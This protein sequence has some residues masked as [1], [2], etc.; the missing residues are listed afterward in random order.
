MWKCFFFV[1]CAHPCQALPLGVNRPKLCK[2]KDGVHFFTLEFEWHNRYNK[3]LLC[4]SENND[5]AWCN[6]VFPFSLKKEQ[7]LILFLFKKTKK[8][9]FLKKPQKTGGLFFFFEKKTGFSQPCHWSYMTQHP[10]LFTLINYCIFICSN[11]H[12]W[13]V[14]LVQWLLVVLLLDGYVIWNNKPL[15]HYCCYSEN[16]NWAAQNLRLGHGFDITGL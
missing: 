14:C 15:C 13:L 6:K 7:N 2:N 8:T 9:C 5:I 11:V 3:L 10:C 1:C 12:Y 16:L 4:N